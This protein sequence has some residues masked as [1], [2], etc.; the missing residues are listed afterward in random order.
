MI[1]IDLPREGW[2]NA[3]R[4]SV[5]C[6]AVYW[7]VSCMFWRFTLVCVESYWCIYCV[8]VEI[9]CS[10]YICLL[11][12]LLCISLTLLWYAQRFTGVFCLFLVNLQMARSVS[13]SILPPSARYQLPF[14]PYTLYA[15]CLFV[16]C[17]LIVPIVCCLL[18]IYLWLTCLLQIV[19]ITEFFCLSVSIRFKEHFHSL[20]FPAWLEVE[21][22]ELAWIHCMSHSC[23][24]CSILQQ[25]KLVTDLVN[26]S[27]LIEV[28][29]I[30]S[31]PQERS[32]FHAL[33]MACL[34]KFLII[35]CQ[36]MKI[37]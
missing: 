26:L 18:L 34:I 6:T 28:F 8:S 7:A 2:P 15:A 9:Y 10:M 29:K 17:F 22:H 13:L 14:T 31:R 23:N 32:W 37:Q 20:H 4:F 21:S 3:R 19:W 1:T 12:G 11:W 27:E 33:L 24:A 36:P 16:H 25:W 30:D 35:I 5:V